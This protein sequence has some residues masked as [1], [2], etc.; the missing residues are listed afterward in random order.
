M[1]TWIS[2]ESLFTTLKNILGKQSLLSLFLSYSCSKVA[3]YYEPHSGLEGALI[4]LK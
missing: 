4:Q 2:L 3:W 1:S